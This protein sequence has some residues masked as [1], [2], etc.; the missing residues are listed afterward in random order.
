[1]TRSHRP[2]RVLAAL[3]V[4]LSIAGLA[5]A[6]DFSDDL[7]AR[8][9]RVMKRLGADAM[10]ILWSAPAKRY[11]NDVDYEYRQDS[12]LYYLTGITQDDT[13][14][15]LMPG[16]DESRREILFVKQRDATREHWRGR[17]MGTEEAGARAGIETVLTTNQFEA[18]AAA[19][20]TGRGFESIDAKQA[21]RF[22][23]ALSAGKA[24]LNLGLDPGRG[25]NDPLTPPLQFAQRIRDR[26]VGFDIA[27]ATPI[28]TDLRL[29]KTPYERKMFVKSFEISNEAQ[30]AGMRAARPGAYEYEVKAA[31]EAVFRR[32]GAVSWAY[33]SIVGSGPNSTILH[34]PQDDRQM[35]AG[36]VL[37]VDAACNYAYM[38]GDITRTYPVSGAFSPAQKEIYQ[39]VLQAQEEGM[40]AAKP[41]SSLQ[42]IHQK[43]VDVIKAGLLKIGLITDTGGDQYKM[44]YTHGASHYIGIDVHDVGTRTQPLAVGMMFTIEPGIY[45]RQSALDALPRT[46]E[47]NALIEKI[48]PAVRK[49]ENIGTRIEDS[50]LIEDSGLL[51]L[52]AA[53]PRTIDEVERFL[54]MRPAAS[55]GSK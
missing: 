19:I 8:R 30:M 50:F 12:N 49:Y 26:F 22:F 53:V 11:S 42:E 40:K 15:V 10:L 52:S 35:Q 36:D 25:V 17:L 47:N 43:T 27:D 20:L 7:K 1:M 13:M 44:W 41:G 23:E 9:A 38:S 34:Y 16:N 54:R 3:L 39:L 5:R 55:T 31:I 48:L 37:L 46:P 45:V 4:V 21:K 32:R 28:L 2:L 29:I 51:R 6:S 33:P 14:L 18:F 24:R